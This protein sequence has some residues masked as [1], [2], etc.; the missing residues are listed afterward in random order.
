VRRATHNRQRGQRSKI[1]TGS[2]LGVANGNDALTAQDGIDH[3][4]SDFIAGHVGQ[5]RAHTVGSQERVG[6]ARTDDLITKNVLLYR[7]G[8]LSAV[9]ARPTAYDPAIGPHLPQGLAVCRPAAFTLLAGQF[10]QQSGRHQAGHILANPCAQG[11]LL[12]RQGYVHKFL[13]NLSLHD[14]YRSCYAVY[15]HPD[16]HSAKKHGVS[17]LVEPS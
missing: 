12:G 3:S 6:K 1:G 9:F 7:A 8:V 5:Y 16:L 10:I 14:G 11:Q 17:Q 4:L 15:R 2:R 13:Q